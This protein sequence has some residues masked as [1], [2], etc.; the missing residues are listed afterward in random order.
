MEQEQLAGKR[1]IQDVPITDSINKIIKAMPLWDF[2]DYG[3]IAVTRSNRFS[4]IPAHTHS[5]IEINYVY[6]GKSIQYI[7]DKKVT[8]KTGQ[9][10]IMDRSVQ[11]RIDYAGEDDILINIL[12]RD[13]DKIRQLLHN[14]NL[15]TNSLTRF[16]FNASQPN[17]NHDNYLIFDFNNSPITLRTTENLIIQGWKNNGTNKSN[18]LLNLLMQTWLIVASENIIFQK[19]N[20]VDAH[21]DLMIQVANYLN[22]HYQDISLK[23]LAR[24]FG[25]SAN[26]LGDKINKE[27]GHSFK[28]LL[29][30]RRLN[31]ACNLIQ[32]TNFSM[33]EISEYIGYDNHSSLFRL[34]KSNLGVS[35]SE[36]RERIIRPRQLDLKSE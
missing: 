29:Q 17:F 25:Y 6:S 4:Y 31:I 5:F 26:Y 18:R 20:Y 36:Y 30:M 32:Q 11:Q 1:H 16:L 34:F 14:E 8:L 33:R 2:F 10:V 15:V 35:P 13:D 22:T 9:A 19:T 12:I 27:T 24:H 23:S 21:Q 7:D 28:Q 3:S